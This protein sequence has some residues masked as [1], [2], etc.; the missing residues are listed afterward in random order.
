MSKKIAFVLTPANVELL[1]KYMAYAPYGCKLNVSYLLN[2]LLN[3][4]L[5]HEL[6]RF[7][8]PASDATTQRMTTYTYDPYK[9]IH[10]SHTTYSTTTYADPPRPPLDVP[11]EA[12]SVS[13][14]RESK[15]KKCAQQATNNITNNVILCLTG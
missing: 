8:P 12:G 5:S 11:L 13:S 4:H 7:E 1:A 15:I 14:S 2:E 6:A 10:S 3:T 9:Y